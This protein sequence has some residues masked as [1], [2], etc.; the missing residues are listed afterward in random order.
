MTPVR[1]SAAAS[2][3]LQ[4]V[5]TG[6]GYGFD[7]MD[8]TGLASGTVYPALR[9]LEALGLVDARWEKHALAQKALRPPRRYY[10][11]TAAGKKALV[12][13]I[14]RYPVLRRAFEGA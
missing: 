7:V 11:V 6:D 14:D 3:V 10:E 13:A 1:L 12:V 5:A 8:A 4:A 2:M 9:R